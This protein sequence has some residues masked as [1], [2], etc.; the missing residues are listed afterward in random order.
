M[1]LWVGKR[2]M[3]MKGGIRRV[4]KGEEGCGNGEEECGEGEEGFGEG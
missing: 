2:R 1:D 3:G 4:W